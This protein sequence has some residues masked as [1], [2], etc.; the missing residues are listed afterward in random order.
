MRSQ[1]PRTP[2]ARS[3]PRSTWPVN[4]L[5]HNPGTGLARRYREFTATV[6]TGDAPTDVLF[7]G[8]RNHLT[9]SRRRASL[10]CLAHDFLVKKTWRPDGCE[11]LQPFSPG[12]GHSRQSSSP[13]C[14]RSRRPRASRRSAC[15]SPLGIQWSLQHPLTN[16]GEVPSR[17]G[18]IQR[19]DA[20]QG[21]AFR[22]DSHADL[23]RCGY[24]AYLPSPKILDFVSRAVT[25]KPDCQCRCRD[26]LVRGT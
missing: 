5:I 1:L 16:A 14:V 25:A 20:K 24:R 8:D 7:V 26:G 6:L 19:S 3:P 15:R 22:G 9:P 2:R 18:L 13:R 23:A 17:R 21:H 4:G 10:N 11:V 12:S